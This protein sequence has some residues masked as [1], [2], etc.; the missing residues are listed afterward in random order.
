MRQNVLSA[1]GFASV[2]LRFGGFSGFDPAAPRLS[3]VFWSGVSAVG[4]S[5]GMSAQLRE[6]TAE[7]MIGQIIDISGYRGPNHRAWRYRGLPS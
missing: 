3:G 1:R 4:D 5:Q 6:R 7:H 2:T